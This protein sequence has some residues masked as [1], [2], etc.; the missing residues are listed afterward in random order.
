MLKLSFKL[1]AFL[2]RL[3]PASL[4][5]DL[6]HRSTF[7]GTAKRSF[8]LNRIVTIDVQADQTYVGQERD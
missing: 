7:N 2:H 1:P 8:T 5:T 6:E 3:M 4:I